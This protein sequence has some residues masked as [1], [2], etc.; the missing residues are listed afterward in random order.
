[1]SAEQTRVVTSLAD[2]TLHSKVFTTLF[3]SGMDLIEDIASY[4]DGQGKKDVQSLS[5]P[6]QLEYATGTMQLTT[7]VMKY[8]SWLL[9]H[10]S[11]AESDGLLAACTERTV[12]PEK[13]I[14]VLVTHPQKLKELVERANVIGKE[15][16]RLNRLFHPT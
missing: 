5:R 8:A 14:E 11:V 2:K 1:M 6:A 16:H 4:L 12:L 15:I 13:D 3:R 10:R 7:Q 9:V